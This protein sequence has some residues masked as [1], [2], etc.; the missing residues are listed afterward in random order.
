MANNGG[1]YTWSKTPA[2]NATA[3]STVNYQEGQAP[4]SL[5][6]SA[7]S[8]MASVAKYRDDISGSIVTSGTS[9]AYILASNQNFDSLTDFHGKVI[10]FSPHVTNAIGPVTMTVD[11]FPNLP[12]RSAPG[13]ELTA[14]VLVQGTPYVVTYNNTDGALY[15]QGF[16]NNPY[17][18][19][20]LGGMEYWDTIT[21][22]SAFIFPLGQAL[23]RTV[24]SRAF[25]RWG[26]KY[27]AGDGSTTFNAP[28]KAGKVSAMI[29]PVASLLTAGFFGGDSTQIGTV[30]G[31]EKHTLTLGETPAGITSAGSASGSMSGATGAVNQGIGGSTTG[32]GS[33]AFNYPTANGAVGV[34]VS[35]TLGA[36][37]ASNNTGGQPHAIVQPTIMCN[38]IIRVL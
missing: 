32:G 36:S 18:V 4:S 8:L 3:D 10:A 34:S 33:F 6:D 24:F 29:E 17:S 1:V 19:P 11:G 7:R 9:A 37:V 26:T 13:V 2:A 21:P 31:S 5:N 16:Y 12:V 20:F 30:S 35:G 22:N 23:S 38:Y 28:N 25:G 27:G 15:L 14:G